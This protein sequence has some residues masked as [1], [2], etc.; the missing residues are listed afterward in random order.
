[1]GI[2]RQNQSCKNCA[3]LGR[4]CGLCK[5]PEQQPQTAAG[6]DLDA[7]LGVDDVAGPSHD[8]DRIRADILSRADAGKGMRPEGQDWD[9]PSSKESSRST[10]WGPAQAV[11]KH[12]H[13]FNEYS[14]SQHAGYKLSGKA[15]RNVP[16]PFR[17]DSGWYSGDDAG[18]PAIVGN[19][20]LFSASIVE[21]S[22][23]QMRSEHPDE[24]QE[25]TGEQ[26]PASDSKIIAK[27]EFLQAHA[28][29]WI[30]NTSRRNDV[31]WNSDV[32]EGV[33]E[34]CANLGKEH[35]GRYAEERHFLVDAERYDSQRSNPAKSYIVDP[36]VDKEIL[37]LIPTSP[38]IIQT[39]PEQ[40][41]YIRAHR[42]DYHFEGTY[43][44]GTGGN[45][46]A[47]FET[48]NGAKAT[49]EMTN[50]EFKTRVN[51]G[52]LGSG[53]A[54]QTDLDRMVDR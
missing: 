5:P 13:D 46:L 54:T 10:P 42:D 48:A 21:S 37:T 41:A 53:F 1:M 11:Y 9:F 18:Y 3:R 16:E 25:W 22:L 7:A 23:N 14:T 4:P 32:P 35:G 34:V 47:V 45:R 30:T 38:D 27:R 29:H 15:Q 19:P 17:K 28:E 8:A 6:T 26:V 40:R 50:Q 36:E 52:H 51:T 20:E 31:S 24:W 12:R 43:Y 33:V 44:P 2:T 49:V 39:R